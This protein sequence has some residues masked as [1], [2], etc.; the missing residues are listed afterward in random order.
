MSSQERL[1]DLADR[2]RL[3]IAQADLHRAL[4]QAECV[5]A[6]VRLDWLD[7]AREKLRGGPWL[8]AGGAVGG[9]LAARH[10]RTALKWVPAALA[11][12]RWL[13]RLKSR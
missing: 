12:W 6:R 11:A 5:N 10:W 7:A 4:I 3:L 8:L 13:R 2:K 1:N 9:M